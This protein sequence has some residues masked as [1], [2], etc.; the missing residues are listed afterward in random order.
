MNKYLITYYVCILTFYLLQLNPKRKC[1]N[2]RYH[3]QVQNRVLDLK[4][5]KNYFMYLNIQMQ[6]NI[7]SPSSVNC[8]LSLIFSKSANS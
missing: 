6:T 1:D 5:Y 7:S 8:G 3:H 4:L 2:I